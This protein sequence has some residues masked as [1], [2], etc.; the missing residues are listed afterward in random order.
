M[1]IIARYEPAEK[2][3]NK[4]KRKGEVQIRRKT[5]KRVE[6]LQSRVKGKDYG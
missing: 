3:K 5:I 1:T 2:K 4:R 6:K